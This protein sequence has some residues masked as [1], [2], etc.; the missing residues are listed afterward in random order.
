MGTKGI[1]KYWHILLN[2]SWYQFCR[3][4]QFRNENDGKTKMIKMFFKHRKLFE[5]LLCDAM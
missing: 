5:S 4:R 3:K 1:I 2:E